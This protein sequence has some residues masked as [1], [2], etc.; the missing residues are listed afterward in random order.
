MLLDHPSSGPVGENWL[1]GPYRSHLATGCAS[2]GVLIS[3]GVQTV[4][5]VRVF[6]VDARQD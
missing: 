3:T 6:Q 2:Y 4:L 5:Q 1:G